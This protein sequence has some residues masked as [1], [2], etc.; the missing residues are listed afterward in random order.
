MFKSVFA[1]YITTFILIIVISFSMILAIVLS[2]V[3]EHSSDLRGEIVQSVAAATE[4]Y[5]ELKYERS[6]FNN[7]NEFVHANQAEIFEIVNSVVK[8][9]DGVSVILADRDGTLL[10]YATPSES[11]TFKQTLTLPRETVD[12]LLAGERASLYG[13]EWSVIENSLVSC[14]IPLT[15]D[16]GTVQ[17]AIIAGYSGNSFLFLLH[18]LA[19]AILV[20]TLWVMVAT[21]IAVY[22]VTEMITGPLREMSKAAKSFAKGRFD[23]RVPVR[24]K[25][26][27]A[28]LALAFNNMAQSLENLESM[29]NN[30][31]ANVSHDLRTP[32]TTISGFID[33][34]L[35]GAIPKEEQSYYLG[36]IKDEVRRLS[37]LVSSL[38]DISRLQAGDR[39][40][41]ISSFDICELARLILISFEQKID[42]KRLNVEFD[43][44]Q[45]RIFVMADRDAIHQILYNICDN[46]IKFASEGGNYR[47]KIHQ[48]VLENKKNK[49]IVSVYNQGEGIAEE[50]LPFVFERFYKADKSRGLDKS[51]VGLGMFI[52]KTIIE[53]HEE[54]IWVESKLHEYCE[55]FFTLSPDD[56]KTK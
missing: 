49:I 8:S 5:L 53:A 19:K 26:E 45:D 17:G 39:K 35:I 51:G 50:D 28:E 56:T 32:M 25:D 21:L 44:E 1:K 7:F 48:S 22:F 11:G 4:S 34:I 41:N 31:M 15:D 52:S 27:V 37:R 24:G 3:T 43:C 20:S 2:L 47:I 38:L 54:K 16:G 14:A 12:L 55:F 36:V 10:L 30:F 23:V 33:N 42:Q 6:D 40:F 46:G 13:A 29:R 9:W 18:D